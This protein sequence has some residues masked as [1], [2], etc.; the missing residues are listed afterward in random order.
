MA[1]ERHGAPVPVN[2]VPTEFIEDDKTNVMC[3]N[4]H[5]AAEISHGLIRYH[6]VLMIP[7]NGSRKL[8]CTTCQV[9]FK[10]E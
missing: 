7:G 6:G 2:V 10:V 9:N 1:F 8:K 5:V 3:P 4:G